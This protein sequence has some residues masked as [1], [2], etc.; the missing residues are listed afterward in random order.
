LREEGPGLTLTLQSNQEELD[1]VKAKFSF[2]RLNTPPPEDGR[3]GTEAFNYI[4]DPEFKPT[5]EFINMEREKLGRLPRAELLREISRKNKE[6]SKLLDDLKK[7]RDH[8]EIRVQERTAELAKANSWLRKEITERKRAEKESQLTEQNFRNSLDSSPLGIRIVTADGELL[9]A[10]QAILDIYGY[11]S[12]K[13]LN[14]MPAKQRY[15]PESY[16]EHQERAKR[17]KLGK[18]VPSSYE[19]SIVRKDGEIRH[20]LVSRKEV[21]WG[22]KMQFQSIYQDITKRKQAEKELRESEEKYR[23]LGENLPQKIFHK[24]RDS[25]YVSCNENFARDF[26]LLPDEIVGKT[27]YDLFPKDLAEKYREDDKRIIESEKTEELEER[28]IQDGQELWVQTVK[29]PIRDEKGNTAGILGIFRDITERRRMEENLKR[30]AKEWRTTFDSITDLVSIHDKD[31]KF[32]RVNKSFAKAFE[33]EP[34]ELIGKTCY[35]IVHGTNEPWPN[36]PHKQT[37]KDRKPHMAEFFEPHLGVHLQTST[38]PIFNE[39]GELVGTVHIARDISERKKMQEQLIVSDRLASIGELAA[40]IAHELNNPLTTVIGFSQLLIDRDLPDDVKEDLNMVYREAQRTAAIVKNLLTFGRK[41]APVKEAVN[42]SSAIEKVLELRAYEQSVNNIK[43]ITRF[44]PNLPEVMVDYFQLQQ[45]FL[46]II[47]N[48][49]HFMIEANRRGTLTITTEKVGNIIK[50]SFADDG[51]GIDRENL[52]RLFDPFFTTK[53]VGKGTGLGLSICHG[54][55][56]EHGGRIYAESE[57]G[58]G[59]TFIVELP[60][61]KR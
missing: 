14:A 27:D 61:N 15:T 52:G 7:A 44:A 6:L 20:L 36:C 49:E 26:K 33:M 28:Y 42:I 41:H 58:K 50:A 47:I 38:S 24:D 23:T 22:A 2:D 21:I 46:N 25:V 16:A 55:I 48:A 56:T 11:G 17:R 43:V 30:A 34:K 32:V 8:L 31:F 18:P 12:V 45:V 5:E 19:I 4:P 1:I 60:I 37:L 57:L 40:G 13:E 39:K 54:M 35:K 51:P 3:E 53:E 59:A 29:T 9:Y 10:N